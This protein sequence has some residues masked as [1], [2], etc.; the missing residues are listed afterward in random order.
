MTK[1]AGFVLSPRPSANGL[2]RMSSLVGNNHRGQRSPNAPAGPSP[3]IMRRRLLALLE[4]AI[5]IIDD[6]DDDDDEEDELTSAKQSGRGRH[7]SKNGPP[8]PSPSPPSSE[9]GRP[10][11]DP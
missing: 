6:D 2:A 5:S 3:P 1:Q 10:R 11:S 8:S 7:D 9:E 4:E